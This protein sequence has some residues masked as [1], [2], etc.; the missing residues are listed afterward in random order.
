MMML[1]ILL[2]TR[3]KL[4]ANSIAL[5]WLWAFVWSKPNYNDTQ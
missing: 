1:Y 4:A 3:Y 5:F 2:E